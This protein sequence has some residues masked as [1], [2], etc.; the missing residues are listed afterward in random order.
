M[1]N[2]TVMIIAASS[3]IGGYL[4]HHYL[5][6]GAR[7]YGTYRSLTPEV[8]GL[9][10]EGVVFFPLD[11]SSVNSINEFVVALRRAEVCW[12]VLISAPGLLSPI[13][14]FFQLDFAEWERSVT[15]NSFSQL[16]VLHAVYPLRTM[17]Q[18][19]KVIFFAGGGTNG[20]FDNYSAYCI[21]KLALIKMT[22]LLDSEC[23]D[24]QVSTIGTGWV[25]TKIHKQTL[26]AG[27]SAGMNWQKTRR[28]LESDKAEG[29]SLQSVAECIDWCISAP[30][31][32]VGGR[33]FSLVFD[34]WR[35]RSFTKELER[36]SDF[37]K[38]R[39]RVW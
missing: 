1:Q 28:F 33:N 30:R 13:G 15:V 36:E 16:R 7:V 37:Y 31:A 19:A 32:A 3:D 17:H 38:L 14:Q 26:A 2:N 5:Q 10:A 39:R 8:S 25:N 11:I 22:E 23:P 34:N 9:M 24:L 27:L 6:R 4:A 21:G 12:D 18:H 20:S 35:D 29:T